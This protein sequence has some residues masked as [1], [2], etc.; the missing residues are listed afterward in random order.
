MLFRSAEKRDG[1]LARIKPTVSDAD[2]EGC[3]LIIEAVFEDRDLKA[4][5]T[6][7][8]ES[9]ALAD[10]VIASNTSTLPITGLATAVQKQDKF[11]GL[12]FFSP[13]DKMP[14]LEIIVG[15]NAWLQ[16]PEVRRALL[17]NPRLATDQIMKVLR[18]TPKHELKLAA[19]QT[20][21][22]HTVRNAAKLVLDDD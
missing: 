6:A 3:D 4:K 22:P 17:S 13:V 14:L 2:F 9:A 19:I 10:A 1:I 8:A 12:H 11:I 5:V 21:Y 7:A 20:A 18:L 16:I 15:N